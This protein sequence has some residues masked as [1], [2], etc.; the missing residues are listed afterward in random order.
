[1]A[2]IGQVLTTVV[3]VVPDLVALE[4]E[5]EASLAALKAS[6]KKPSDYMKFAAAQLIAAAPVA[7]KLEP[8]FESAAAVAAPAV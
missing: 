8:I 6:A 2:N 3:T 7:D 1:M 5:V 4:A